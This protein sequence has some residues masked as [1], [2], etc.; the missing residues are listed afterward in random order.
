MFGYFDDHAVPS[1]ERVP[2]GPPLILPQPL[3]AVDD[4][5]RAASSTG[6]RAFSR[7]SGP[8]GQAMARGDGLGASPPPAAEPFI[9]LRE[10]RFVHALYPIQQVAHVLERHRCVTS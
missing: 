7:A 3:T 6:Q 5:N 8:G 10:Q 9:E 4:Q 1:S 2:D